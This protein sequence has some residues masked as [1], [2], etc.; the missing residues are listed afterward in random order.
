MPLFFLTDRKKEE[1]ESKQYWISFDKKKGWP[2]FKVGNCTVSIIYA[3]THEII[4]RSA[5]RCSASIVI[6]KNISVAINIVCK[7]LFHLMGNNDV[8]SKV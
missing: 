3:N 1:S 8:F 4:W 7:H 5:L 6:L 2:N